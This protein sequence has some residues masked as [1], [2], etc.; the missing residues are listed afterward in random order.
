MNKTLEPKKT[1]FNYYMKYVFSYLLINI[2]LLTI[3][4]VGKMVFDLLLMERPEGVMPLVLIGVCVINFLLLAISLFMV[5]YYLSK[6][7][8]SKIKSI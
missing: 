6:M 8:F 4:F 7:I 2:S 1:K 5:I 3:Y